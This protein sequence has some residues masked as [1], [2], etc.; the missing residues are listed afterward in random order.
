MRNII[1]VAFLL[2]VH[3]FAYSIG[4]QD[5]FESY[6]TGSFP[7]KWSAFHSNADAYIVNEQ[8]NVHQGEQAACL[9]FYGGYG[10]GIQTTFEAIPKGVLT[11]YSKIEYFTDDLQL[12]G[13]FNTPNTEEPGSQVQYVKVGDNSPNY[14]MKNVGFGIVDTGVQI[15]LGE[16]VKFQLYFDSEN[17]ACDLYINDMPTEAMNIPFQNPSNGITTL[18]SNHE[19]YRGNPSKWYLDDVSIVPEPTSICL[20]SLGVIILKRRNK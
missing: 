15:V 3:S 12:M 17:S 13:I 1:L 19:T 11:F 18:R 20:I 4:F 14:T 2:F 7:A 6:N 9:T 10:S 16:Y 8:F 5:D